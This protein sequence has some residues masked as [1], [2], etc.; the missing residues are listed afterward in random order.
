[1]KINKWDFNASTGNHILRISPNSRI[2]RIAG[3]PPYLYVGEFWGD[4]SLKYP[5]K[6]DWCYSLK[7][8]K[9][10]LKQVE[11]TCSIDT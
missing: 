2:V 11:L 7:K 9:E 3:S 8:V 4:Y 5:I 1:M 10:E 6:T